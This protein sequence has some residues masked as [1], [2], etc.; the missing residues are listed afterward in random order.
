[1]SGLAA[2]HAEIMTVVQQI[3]TDWTT[4]TLL[5]ETDNREAIDQGAQ[6]NPYLKVSIV[7]LQAEQM[8]LGAQPFKVQYSQIL[9]S[10]CVKSGAG[11]LAGKQL[12]DF[13]APYFDLKDFTTVRCHEFEAVKA[14]KVAGWWEMPAVVNF[15]FYWR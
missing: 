5:V 2:A 15:W 3:V 6:T 13:I 9:L 14:K 1:M 12:L 8:D 11:T 4:Y 7:D 10:V